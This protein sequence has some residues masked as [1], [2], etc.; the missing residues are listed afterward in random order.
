MIANQEDVEAAAR[1]LERLSKGARVM[2][3]VVAFACIADKFG[4][5]ASDLAGEAGHNRLHL[6]LNDLQKA[7]SPF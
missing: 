4:Q 5:T 6:L 1:S 7:A 2:P 3:Q